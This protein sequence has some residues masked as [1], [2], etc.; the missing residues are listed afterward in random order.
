MI[1]T[2]VLFLNFWS[3]ALIR[4]KGLGTTQTE[5]TMS[6]DDEYR[7]TL[8]KLK[9]AVLPELKR[10]GVAR[11]RMDYHGHSDDGQI[12]DLVYFDVEGTPLD[13][14]RSAY[15]LEIEEILSELLPSGYEI[16]VGS[17]GFLTVDVAAGTVTLEHGWNVPEWH[18]TRWEV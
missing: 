3:S 5:E 12:D 8:Q 1:S 16:D 10:L 13:V 18:T 4:V 6:F 17:E 11:L 7:E 2:A 15:E 9:N 14:D